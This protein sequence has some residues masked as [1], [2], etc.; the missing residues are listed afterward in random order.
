MIQTEEEQSNANKNGYRVNLRLSCSIVVYNFLSSYCNRRVVELV[1]SRV[2]Q[3]RKARLG[4]AVNR[5]AGAGV[6]QA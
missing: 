2:R 5:M 1:P 4:K 6:G 3:G